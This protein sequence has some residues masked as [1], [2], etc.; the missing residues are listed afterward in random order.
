MRSRRAWLASGL[1]A[2]AGCAST[3]AGDASQP[4]VVGAV[5]GATAAGFHAAGYLRVEQQGG[6][7]VLVAITT[8]RAIRVTVMGPNVAMTEASGA[9]GFPIQLPAG[10]QMLFT[11]GGDHIMLERVATDLVAGEQVELRL[12]F[13]RADDIVISADVVAPAD[14]LDRAPGAGS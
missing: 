8:E 9:S 3:V 12:E 6:D 14:L 4:F 10:E 7:D 1:I 5:V 13:E 2:L 11:P